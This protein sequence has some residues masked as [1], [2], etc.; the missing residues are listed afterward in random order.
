MT[1]SKEQV[2]EVMR[3]TGVVP[4]FTHDNPEEAQQ[5]VEAAYRGGVR[6]FEFTNRR[7]NSFEIFTHLVSQR[8]KI[9]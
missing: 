5:V 3:D 1:F 2:I 6:T 9:S 7:P 8:K 4:L